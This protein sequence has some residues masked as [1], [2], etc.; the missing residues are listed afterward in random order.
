MYILY[1]YNILFEVLHEL[2]YFSCEEA[3]PLC[4]LKTRRPPSH[5]KF[6]HQLCAQGVQ[7]ESTAM[8]NLESANKVRTKKRI[9]GA[10]DR[11]MYITKGFYLD[12]LVGTFGKGSSSKLFFF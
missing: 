3:M 6:N 2:S 12:G 8:N 4:Q 11:W 7:A 10:Y 9:G 5:S 1:I